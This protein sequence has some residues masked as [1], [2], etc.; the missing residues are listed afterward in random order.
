MSRSNDDARSPL[1]RS[2]T[3]TASWTPEEWD[4]MIEIDQEMDVVGGEA[5][6]RQQIRNPIPNPGGA[7]TDEQKLV[8][9]LDV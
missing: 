2:E 8:S 1:P 7:V 4:G 6:R 3:R 9:R 5:Q